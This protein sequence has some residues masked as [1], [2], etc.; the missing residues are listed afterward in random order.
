MSF[1]MFLMFSFHHFC[2]TGR[3]VLPYQTLHMLKKKK[4][5]KDRRKRGLTGVNTNV[6]KEQQ[7]NSVMLGMCL[8][9]INWVMS[10]Q[11][12]KPS[13]RTNPHGFSWV[14]R[15]PNIL[16]S[17]WDSYPKGVSTCR[18]KQISSDNTLFK[19]GTG[20]HN[21]G[22]TTLIS[23]I[24]TVDHG[25]EF[26]ISLLTVNALRNW[27]NDIQEKKYGSFDFLKSNAMT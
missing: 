17:P 5:Q 24:T 4:P 12:E 13:E 27:D 10:L 9:N 23:T 18:T 26:Q 11:R 20:H 14:W 3:N 15:K 25:E 8:Q 22:R 16:S 19:K 6:V 7:C 2:P 1:F 21:T